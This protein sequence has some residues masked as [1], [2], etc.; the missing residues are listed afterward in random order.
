MAGH[1]LDAVGAA[2]GMSPS[3]AGRIE[4]GALPNVSVD[5]LARLGAAVGL[6]IRVHAY[7]GAGALRDLGQVRL[8]DRLRAR[9]D[10]GLE[11]RTE[12]PLPGHGDQ[13]AWDGRIERL[14]DGPDGTTVLHV[15]AETRLV[16]LQ[17][18]TR[19][20]MLKARDGG[21]SHV[22]LVVADTHRNR[23]A[24]DAAAPSLMEQ[25]PLRGRAVLHALAAGRHPGGSGLLI[26]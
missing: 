10:Q 19:R 2:A 25:F 26:L 22:L 3:Q 20:I 14:L 11:F 4:R 9:L 18:Q 6:D 23:D 13:R 15:E 24:I 8:L 21:V 1:S 5:Q 17:A 7:P 16:D 12:V